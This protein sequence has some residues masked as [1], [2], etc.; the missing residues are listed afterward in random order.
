MKLRNHYQKSLSLILLAAL[1][2]CGGGGGSSD[3]AASNG[4]TSPTT[5]PAGGT[6][7]GTGT[8]TGTGTG[9]GTDTGTGTGT[10]TTTPT[11]P[12]T[13]SPVASPAPVNASMVMSCA[14]GAS[15]QCSGSSIIRIDNGVALTS[16]GVEVYGKSTN[17]LVT[18]IKDPT[19]A[20]GL[21]LTSGGVADIRVDKAANGTVSNAAMVLSSLGISFD[22]IHERPTIVEAFRTMQGRTLLAPNGAI[23]FGALPD[24]SNLGFYDIATKGANA[25][26]DDYAN[27]QYFPR[28]APARCPTY[29]M[30]CPA[31]ETTGIHYTAGNWRTG[32]TIPDLTQ[33]TR[34]HGD[35]DAHAGNGLPDANGNP[36]FISESTAPGVPYAGTKGTRDL[37]NWSFNYA[38]LGAWKTK[39]TVDIAEWGAPNEHNQNRRGLVAY[40]NV[41]DPAAVPTSGTASYT[42]FV[43][44]WYARTAS[45]EAAFFKGDAVIT[46]DFATRQ[47][48]IKLQNTMADFDASEQFA[49]AIPVALTANAAMGA[50]GNNVANYLTGSIDNGSLKGGISG[51]YFGPVVS[52]GTSGAG[53]AEIGGAFSLS[54]AT[55]GQAVVGGFVGRK[56]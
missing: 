30:P 22:G 44:G 16:S 13:P 37:I 45:E 56:Q 49:T 29:M 53:P 1:S 48:T 43:Y 20:F 3:T 24:S 40:G 9:T 25:T 4:N 55:S 38:N 2:A 27:N 52:T 19:T 18:P 50:A 32:G 12:G 34:E 36:T 54:N 14:D 26:Q 47:V 51:R 15:Y 5:A 28:T 10:G 35:G 41:T 46:V 8:T 23:T 7:T 21:T 31:V 39:D 6:G 42:G 17:D 11:T 33:A